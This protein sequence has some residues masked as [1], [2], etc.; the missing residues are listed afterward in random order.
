MQAGVQTYN[1]GNKTEM[2]VAVRAPEGKKGPTQVT[3]TTD[4]PTDA[5]LHW[6]I[7]K[8]GGSD[9]LA[10]P[11][12]IW[13][14]DSAVAEANA[15]ALDTPFLE[16][17]DSDTQNITVSPSPTLLFSCRALRGPFLSPRTPTRRTLPLV[18]CF[19]FRGEWTLRFFSYDQHGNTL[20]ACF[21]SIWKSK[22]RSHGLTMRDF[23]RLP[24]ETGAHLTASIIGQQ[25]LS[26]HQKCI[27]RELGVLEM[28][29]R[30]A[31]LH[32][33]MAPGGQ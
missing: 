31:D 4:L 26:S 27:S 1:M 18:P 17:S 32:C 9:W 16:S 11:Q 21:G 13:P 19:R 28:A 33:V 6:G 25:H 14:A 30:S 20:R 7:K 8:G 10:P 12:E 5:F 2:L 3:L 23:D 15:A 24:S 29:W 22:A